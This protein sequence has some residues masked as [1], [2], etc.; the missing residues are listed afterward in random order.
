MMAARAHLH[1]Q[2]G[3]GS[4][5]RK[6]ADHEIRTTMPLKDVVTAVLRMTGT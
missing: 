1:S 6:A 4:L 2:D 5:L 3:K